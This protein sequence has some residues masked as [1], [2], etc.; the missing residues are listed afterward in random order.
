MKAF[1]HLC[2]DHTCNCVRM[3]VRKKSVCKG[4]HCKYCQCG[5]VTARF[6]AATDRLSCT[7]ELESFVR[8]SL[9]I[10]NR[11]LVQH[12]NF[13]ANITSAR[14]KPYMAFIKHHRR[15]HTKTNHISLFL[16]LSRFRPLSL[17]AILSL[18]HFSVSVCETFGKAIAYYYHNVDR[19]TLSGAT[20]RLQT[21]RLRDATPKNISKSTQPNE[22]IKNN[23]LPFLF[24][25]RRR[26]KAE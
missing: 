15:P 25:H 2:D 18:V 16:S 21:A 6:V 23:I 26:A 19:T 11:F 13:I 4:A 5:R 9:L 10:K 14:M 3:H 22:E 8:K 17:H 20:T 7:R 24:G 1:V 12:H